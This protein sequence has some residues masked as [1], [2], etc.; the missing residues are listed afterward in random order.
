LGAPLARLEGQVVFGRLR[1][2]FASVELLDDNPART[3]GFLRGLRSLP[4]RLQ[5]R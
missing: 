1:E 3:S 5:P 2:R 4:V